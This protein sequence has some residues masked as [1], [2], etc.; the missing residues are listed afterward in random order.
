MLWKMNHFLF[1]A[2]L[3]YFQTAKRSFQGGG[4]VWVNVGSIH[5]IPILLSSVW[6][7]DYRV[8]SWCCL[9]FS[10]KHWMG[11]DKRTPKLLELL[12][13]QGE[14]SVQCGPVGDFLDICH[15]QEIMF[16]SL[17][18]IHLLHLQ[19]YYENSQRTKSR[20]KSGF[21]RWRFFHHQW[22]QKMCVN[23][24][25]HYLNFWEKKHPISTSIQCQLHIMQS[26]FHIS[27]PKRI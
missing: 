26:V 2:I 17:H 9:L 14:G 24:D 25:R 16:K 20:I 15:L 7:E 4:P 8:S 12:D 11:P 10:I 13:T 19:I 3:A 5:W 22:M 18:S 21:D 1:D 27:W 6:L 23:M